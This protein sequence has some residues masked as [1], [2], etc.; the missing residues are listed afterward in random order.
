VNGE[1]DS[2]IPSHAGTASVSETPS[3]AACEAAIG[4]TVC[5]KGAVQ[6]EVLVVTGLYIISSRTLLLVLNPPG[7]LEQLQVAHDAQRTS[8][9]VYSTTR[10][11][12]RG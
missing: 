3:V 12:K 1:G 4:S 10:G 6:L 9:T 2:V 7:V 11:T 8:R 5:Q